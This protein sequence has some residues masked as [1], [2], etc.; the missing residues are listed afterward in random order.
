MLG[1]PAHQLKSYKSP[2]Y[3]AQAHN[4]TPHQPTGS[5]HD[6]QIQGKH[7]D[8]QSENHALIEFRKHKSYL[9]TSSNIN[10]EV[11]KE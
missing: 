4:P 1:P 5:R 9:F 7:Q 8:T 3:P 6:S 10:Y 11:Y 2:V